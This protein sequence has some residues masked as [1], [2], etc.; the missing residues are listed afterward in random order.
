MRRLTAL[1]R[2]ARDSA[3]AA[4]LAELRWPQ[5]MPETLTRSSADHNDDAT[6]VNVHL[7]LTV[8]VIEIATT[9]PTEFIELE[10]GCEVVA[11]ERILSTSYN[12]VAPTVDGNEH[13]PL[14][15]A[16]ALCESTTSRAAIVD[17]WVSGL[18]WYVPDKLAWEAADTAAG[19]G[20]RKHARDLL[21]HS[22]KLPQSAM[23]AAKH[24]L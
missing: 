19:W 6:I 15:E 4:P 24:G 3:P 7:R 21:K 9:D 20:F 23:V 2:K 8:A 22:R 14:G 17:R 1:R 12:W 13:V 11:G 18:P 16:V 10:R 5:P